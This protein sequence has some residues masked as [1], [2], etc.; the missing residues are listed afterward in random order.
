MTKLFRHPLQ[1]S[2]GLLLVVSLATPL[3]GA[4]TPALA[5]CVE[6]PPGSQ[7]VTCTGTDTDGF[8]TWT[9]NWT[10][11]VEAG[12]TVSNEFN[13]A[14]ELRFN[15]VIV[16]DGT[17][18]TEGTTYADGTPTTGGHDG[19]YTARF[20]EVTNN[21]SITTAGTAS[22]GIEVWNDNT[23]TNTGTITTQATSSY[24]IRADLQNNTL[25]NSGTITSENSN[26]GG[27]YLQ[28]AGNTL[29]NSGTI[30]AQGANSQG[31]LMT[32]SGSLTNS[33]SITATNTN[34][35]AVLG[36]AG[37]DTVVNSGTLDGQVSL[38]AGDDQVALSEGAVVTQTID[39][40][41]DSD[42]LSF[43]FTVEASAYPAL[44]AVINDASAP[45]GGTV[46]INGNT[47]S[48]INFEHLIDLLE[49]LGVPAGGTSG[50]GSGG[51]SGAPVVIITINAIPDGRLNSMDFAAT[52]IPFC[53]PDGLDLYAATGGEVD[54]AFH[55]D[56]AAIEAGLA[57]AAAADAPVEI[58]PE[59]ARLDVHLYALASDTLQ[60]NGADGYAYTF[61][62]TVCG[63][64]G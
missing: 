55:V 49:V 44:A 41:A 61:A 46:T 29:D 17:I 7:V 26:S 35:Y 37:A 12:A 20:G 60:V 23:I 19:I 50:S 36:S 30:E 2:M 51:G 48:W 45:A 1:L 15:N 28:G 9:D 14:I 63:L 42:S 54:F 47:Y 22:N 11:T 53:A 31:V 38:G 32:A 59:A 24:G 52:A 58:V 56:A 3:A 43:A 57:A 4:L 62:S 10:V 21:G 40:G 27:V 18:T 34:S 39:G 33:G 64:G 6:D 8:D 13:K 25:D 5:Q 16:N